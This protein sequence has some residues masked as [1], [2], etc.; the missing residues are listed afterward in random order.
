MGKV[1]L[2]TPEL[3][4]K[5]A[6]GEVIERPASVV[7]ELLE[8]ALDADADSIELHLKDSG[9]TLIRLK[10]SG[11]GIEPDDLE[12]IFLRHT[13]SKIRSFDD[14][15]SI[16]S[17]G[18][19]GEALYTIGA[20]SDVA[21]RSR[22]RNQDTGWEIHWRGGEKLSLKPV[23]MEYGTEVEIQELFFNTPARKKFLKGHTTELNQILN[24]FLPYTLVCEGCSFS[25][26]HQEKD[27]LDLKATRNRLGRIASSLNLKEKHLIEVQ[28]DFPEEEISIHMILGDINIQRTRRDL[29]FIFVNDRPVQNRNL[30]FHMNQVYRLLFPEGVYPFFALYLGI[31]PREVDVNIHPTKREVKIK[32]EQRV[33][34]MLRSLTEKALMNRGSPKE[35]FLTSHDHGEEFT[36]KAESFQ[37]PKYADEPY[38]FQLTPIAP[39]LSPEGSRAP[40]QENLQNKLSLGR[41]I[42]SFL[43]KYLLFETGH[44]LFLVDQHA[45]QERI[46]YEYFRKQMEAGRVEIQTLLMPIVMRLSAVEMLSWEEA[47]EKLKTIG[48]ETTQ[49]DKESI[50]LHTHPQLIKNPELAV[51]ELLSG[52]NVASCDHD[53]IARRA[54]RASIMAGD[55]LTAQQA[56]Y[57][58][59]ELLRCADPFTCPHGRPTVVEMSEGFLDKQFLRT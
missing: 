3:I 14:L 38:A 11:T 23:V 2:L 9:K 34:L 6:A 43:K 16:R 22:T 17:L 35:V 41:Y 15:F 27:L 24:I 55:S 29:Q 58:R 49:W 36:R 44:S 53:T 7:K 52:G 8:N 33:A 31:P 18:F 20:V 25:L 1:H 13:T 51:R 19:R 28:Q 26:S 21:L 56:E 10:D 5:I 30:G 57:Q 45:A 59:D 47:E 48:L 32:E 42:G 12:K 54:C 4:S 46:M 50:A 39:L 37:L 40:R